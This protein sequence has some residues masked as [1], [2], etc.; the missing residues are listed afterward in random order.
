ML[1][2]FQGALN[3]VLLVA[4]TNWPEGI[5]SKLRCSGRLDRELMVPLPDARQRQNILKQLIAVHR[6]RLSGDEVADVA[7]RAYGFSG[8]DLSVL[9]RYGWLNCVDERSSQVSFNPSCDYK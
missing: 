3:P 9:I 1:S 4:A 8:A 5:S 2:S 7:K 6:H